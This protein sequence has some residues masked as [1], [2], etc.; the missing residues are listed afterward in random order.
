MARGTTKKGA[1]RRATSKAPGS[2]PRAAKTSEN[3]VQ[4][5]GGSVLGEA[6]KKLAELQ[7]LDPS[8]GQWSVD[9]CAAMLR[10]WQGVFIDADRR[11]QETTGSAATLRAMSD[12]TTASRE[13][14]EWEK[15]KA[16]A[17][18]SVRVDLLR[19]ILRRLDEQDAMSD[20][21]LDIEE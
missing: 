3:L 7:A 17:L 10:Y 19:E 16:G 12:R 20:E 14:G 9:N 1:S 6:R 5:H 11:L 15:R 8:T 2:P 18:I 21:L 13:A 4:P